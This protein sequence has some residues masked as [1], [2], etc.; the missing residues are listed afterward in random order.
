MKIGK[1]YCV[2]PYENTYIK[3]FCVLTTGK[4]KIAS[5]LH[6]YESTNINHII[7]SGL[8]IEPIEIDE[9]K[10]RKNKHKTKKE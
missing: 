8:K 1:Q 5:S 3:R 6:V 9:E 10:K 2:A 4:F 7:I